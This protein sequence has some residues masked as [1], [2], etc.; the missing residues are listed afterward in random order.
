MERKIGDSNQ[1]QHEEVAAF[2]FSLNRWTSMI[3]WQGLSERNFTLPKFIKRRWHVIEF[4]L[5]NVIKVRVFFYPKLD[6]G[7]LGGFYGI[8]TFVGYLM[9]DEFLNR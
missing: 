3:S 8:S 2:K 9:Q 6:L 5:D 7:W 4:K 1:F